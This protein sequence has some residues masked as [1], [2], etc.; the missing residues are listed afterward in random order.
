[1]AKKRIVKK[2]VKNEPKEVVHH[3]IDIPK[4]KLVSTIISLEGDRP[5]LVNNKLG[6]AERIAGQYDSVGKTKP[7]L[8]ALSPDE[9][10]ALAF[11][12]LPNSKFQPP[13]PKGDYGI[14]CSGLKKC[15]CSAIRTAG[16]TDN[17][18]IGLISKSFWILE[19]SGGFCRLSFKRLE[20][21]IRPVNIGSGQKTVPSMRHRPMFHD[22]KIQVKV[23]YN[24]KVLSPE[25]LVNLFMHAGQFIGLCEM[26]AE[27]KQGQ[28][29]GF[30]VA[31][32]K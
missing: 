18:T 23:R 15:V 3:A 26:R 14:P 6:I 21:D 11:Y 7:K 27:K 32:H 25:A 24:P 5:L 2:F 13:S 22:W 28:C 30:V 29:G 16:F 1:M 12:V 17:T 31:N 20:R 8:E 19:D 9:Q 10:Y 4:L